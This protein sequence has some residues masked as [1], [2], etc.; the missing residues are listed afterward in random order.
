MRA[1]IGTIRSGSGV[2]S[3]WIIQLSSPVRNRAYP[4]VSLLPCR[5]TFTSRSSHLSVS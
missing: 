1:S 4:P 5:T 3:R 2:R